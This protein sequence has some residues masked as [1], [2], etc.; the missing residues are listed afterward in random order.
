MYNNQQIPIGRVENYQSAG[1]T[2]SY[3][4]NGLN[5]DFEYVGATEVNVMITDNDVNDNVNLL[6][7]L[8]TLKYYVNTTN[9]ISSSPVFN[10]TSTF[11][12]TSTREFRVTYLEDSGFDD[13]VRNNNHQTLTSNNYIELRFDPSARN[14]SPYI[15]NTL[16]LATNWNPKTAGNPA[17]TTFTWLGPGTIYGQNAASYNSST[18]LEYQ[19]SK[20][21]KLLW[22]M[23]DYL[24]PGFEDVGQYIS[25]IKVKFTNILDPSMENIQIGTSTIN[26]NANSSGTLLLSGVTINY[27]FVYSSNASE[28]TFSGFTAT[29]KPEALLNILKYCHTSATPTIGHR[30]IFISE[31]KDNINDAYSNTVIDYTVSTNWSGKIKINVITPIPDAFSISW[32]ASYNYTVIENSSATTAMVLKVNG[33]PSTSYPFTYNGVSCLVHKISFKNT[34]SNSEILDSRLNVNIG[35]SGK[36]V[37]DPAGLSAGYYLILPIANTYNNEEYTITLNSVDN[38]LIDGNYS[39]TISIYDSYNAGN[40]SFNSNQP[41]YVLGDVPT[42]SITDDE[43]PTFTAT[44]NTLSVVEGQT[45]TVDLSINIFPASNNQS[46]ELDM[47]NIG[48][49]ARLGISPAYSYFRR[50]TGTPNPVDTKTVTV[51]FTAHQNNNVDGNTTVPVTFSL[52]DLY[53]LNG[54]SPNYTRGAAAYPSTTPFSGLT[55]TITIN[56]IDDDVPLIVPT[57]SPVIVSETTG[58]NTATTGIKLSS[59]PVGNVTVNLTSTS[60]DFTYSPA[61]MTFTSSNWSTAQTLTVT[62]VNNTIIDGLRTGTIVMTDPANVYNQPYPITVKVSD[63]D[64]ILL[65][66]SLNNNGTY[67]T[68]TSIEPVTSTSGTL[69][70]PDFQIV[71]PAQPTNN[72]VINIT[73]NPIIVPIIVNGTQVGSN[74]YSIL[75]LSSTTLTFTTSNWNVP[76][77]VTLNPSST[78]MVNGSTLNYSSLNGKS[79]TLSLNLSSSAASEYQSLNYTL[80][81]S[82]TTTSPPASI[83]VGSNHSFTNTSTGGTDNKLDMCEKNSNGTLRFLLN[84]TQASNSGMDI[85]NIY[86]S[87][88]TSSISPH[89]IGIFFPNSFSTK[90]IPCLL[91][92]ATAICI[93]L[94][95]CVLVMA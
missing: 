38:T 53:Y 14:N 84:L 63:D 37:K 76:Q 31:L 18:V 58:S 59:A 32:N 88:N 6:T 8:L 9:A 60:S 80:G 44:T 56:V 45:V 94:G 54:T 74:S 5:F 64:A 43:F 28:I 16:N 7:E 30:T 35:T 62:S 57:V 40:T 51:T 29:V 1:Y 42:I 61:S 87:F 79:S 73:A 78:D 26:L 81:Y 25:Q 41:N 22:N 92:I 39:A 77:I 91:A 69:N 90:S 68:V 71:L 93:S 27:S 4:Y 49:N 47:T 52:A 89:Q 21:S 19:A 23:S 10:Y 48:T 82:V 36:I 33:N 46:Y 85:T 12:I 70:N 66:S 15:T 67:P 75:N 65:I 50:V 3:T 34:V 24:S 20:G 2:T 13:G 95:C 86:L 17:E 11:T 83:L 72:V 55:Q